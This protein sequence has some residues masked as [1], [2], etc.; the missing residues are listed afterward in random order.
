[1]EDE[2]AMQGRNKG[3]LCLPPS[4]FLV[5]ATS[6][7]LYRVCVKPRHKPRWRLSGSLLRGWRLDLDTLN[8][9]PRFAHLPLSAITGI[10]RT[11]W[12]RV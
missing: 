11:Q 8:R 5:Q 12:K 2:S 7:E 1:M 3:A 6:E 10:S 9:T 4:L